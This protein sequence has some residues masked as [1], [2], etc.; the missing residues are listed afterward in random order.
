MVA[1]FDVRFRVDDT[2]NALSTNYNSG[3]NNS[4]TLTNGTYYLADLCSEVETQL[5][6]VNASYTCTESDGKVT[7]AADDGFTVSWT[8]PSLRDWLGW[9]A[10]LS[11]GDEYVGSVSPGT[12]VFRHSTHW[13]VDLRLHTRAWGG[14]HQRGSSI[15]TANSRVFHFEE[16]VSRADLVDEL[17]A[18]LGY[19]LRGE[20]VR[21]WRDK[22]VNT[23]FDFDSQPDGYTDAIML[24]DSY[25]DGWMD[26]VSLVWARLPFQLL[27]VT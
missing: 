15:K 3:G 19:M 10:N 5:Q 21:W 22:T 8:H 13:H 9:S 12:H 7:L 17:R 14:D 4:L 24:D 27:E 16:T 6:T 1:R 23:A 11:G 2:T 20:R 26:D 25:D 18:V